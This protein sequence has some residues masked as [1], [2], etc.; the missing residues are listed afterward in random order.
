MESISI[1]FYVSVAVT[2]GSGVFAAILQGL[3]FRQKWKEF[4]SREHFLT[5]KIYEMESLLSVDKRKLKDWIH[6]YMILEGKH[7]ELDDVVK[8]VLEKLK[9]YEQDKN[10]NDN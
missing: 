9:E 1:W 4:E 10:A 7:Y 5:L 2:C 6:R 8:F 3:I